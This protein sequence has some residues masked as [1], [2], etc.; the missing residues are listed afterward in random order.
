MAKATFVKAARKAVPS[1]GINVGDSYY[2]W[3]FRYGGKHYSKTPP[4]P[5]Q[6]TQS[7]FLAQLYAIQEDQGDLPA[8]DNLPSA[9][10]DLVSRLNDLADECESN[11][12]NM[13]ESLQDSETGQLLESRADA[14]RS[15]A[16]ELEGLD[17]SEWTAEEKECPDCNGSG[18]VDGEC[19][20]CDGLGKKPS[21]TSGEVECGACEGTG[22][23]KVPCESCDGIGKLGDSDVDVDGLTE[24]EYWSGKLEELIRELK[25]LYGND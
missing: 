13:P 2:W 11:R 6:L 7:N 9:V 24:D 15:A 17:L 14:C 19:E 25:E 1:A 4:K 23:V 20:A 12:E 18:E 22:S 5:S 3:A 10:E 16:D 21:A 8:D